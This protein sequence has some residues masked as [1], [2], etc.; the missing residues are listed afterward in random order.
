MTMTLI[1]TT[2]LGTAGASIEFTS[3]PQTF[4]DLVVF[5]SC[6][7]NRALVVDGLILNLNGSAVS[8]TGRKLEGDGGATSSSTT[9]TEAGHAPANTATA[10]TFSNVFLYFPNYTGSTNKSFSSDAVSENNASTTYQSLYAGLWS[11]TAAITSLRIAPDVGTQLS[12]DSTI[13]LYGILKGSD[14]I[15]T[16]S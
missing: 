15:V 7:T 11:N 4:T 13:S 6:R 1:Q 12:V 10:N 2:T 9:T 16:V 3:I 14:G 5:M 8:F